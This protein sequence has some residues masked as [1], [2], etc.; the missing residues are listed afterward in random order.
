MIKQLGRADRISGF[1]TIILFISKWSQVRDFKEI[2]DRATKNT[3]ISST[4]SQRFNTNKPKHSSSLA[5]ITVPAEITFSDIKSILE[6]NVEFE[7]NKEGEINDSEF[8]SI[9]L[10]TKSKITNQKKIIKKQ[11]NQSKLQKGTNLPDKFFDH[12]YCTPYRRL[13]SLARYND[14]TYAINETIG[15]GKNILTLCYNSPSYKSIEPEFL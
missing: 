7:G 3:T 13:F 9:L 6:F 15:L 11:K 8:L 1:C 2:E 14:M 5:Q 12:I 4:N 10:A